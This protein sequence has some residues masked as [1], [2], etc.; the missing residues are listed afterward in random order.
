MF[1]SFLVLKRNKNLE[2]ELGKKNL[3]CV[4]QEHLK[5]Y[6]FA[7][8]RFDAKKFCC[9]K[10]AYPGPGQ[11]LY[12]PTT[13]QFY[14]SYK[15]WW[16]IYPGSRTG[17]GSRTTWSLSAGFS[18]RESWRTCHWG[19]LNHL[20]PPG[21]LH[22]ISWAVGIHPGFFCPATVFIH[23]S[24]RLVFPHCEQ[25]SVTPSPAWRVEGTEPMHFLEENVRKGWRKMAKW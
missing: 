20:R 4:S 23:E 8:F 24:H 22:C 12:N 18:G 7:S 14:I 6:C 1:L 13:R 10:L 15:C 3:P 21:S 25:D 11:A 19:N 17:T 16:A 5:L 2:V 9:A